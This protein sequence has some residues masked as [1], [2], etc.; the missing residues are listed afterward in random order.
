MLRAHFCKNYCSV[1]MIQ[2]QLLFRRLH[3][4]SK[5][6]YT[7]QSILY[8]PPNSLFATSAR[9]PR[10]IQ[11]LESTTS[12]ASPPPTTDGS[13]SGVSLGAIFFTSLCAATFGL[14]VWQTKRYFEKIEL[15]EKREEDLKSPALQFDEWL[16]NNQ[17]NN[18]KSDHVNSH[19]EIK[20][21]KEKKVQRYRLVSIEG[22]FDH[23]HQILIGPR[24]PPPGALAESG[25]NSGRGG[26]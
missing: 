12:K 5:S 1:E 21:V 18:D 17:S 13:S 2:Q 10:H 23:Q 6:S 20:T 22:P 9:S 14:G 4:I 24:G 16:T 19:A 15:V 8:R 26:G 7:T 3:A 25:P 11:R